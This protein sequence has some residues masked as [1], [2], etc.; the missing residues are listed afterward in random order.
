MFGENEKCWLLL[1]KRIGNWW[2]CAKLEGFE[3]EGVP[4]RVHFDGD[5]VLKKEEEDQ[6]VVGW[7]HTHPTFIAYPSGTD[8]ATMRAWAGC[9]GKP[10]LCGIKG[11]DGLKFY[12]YENDEDPGRRVRHVKILNNYYI[13]G[14]WKMKT[15]MKN[16]VYLFLLFLIGCNEPY[17]MGYEAGINGKLTA[18]DNPFSVTNN[19]ISWENGFDAGVENRCYKHDNEVIERYRA[20]L[21]DKKEE[22][23]D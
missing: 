1:G 7:I 15:K 4:T 12:L 11:T 20:T 10:L 22:K 21:T 3:H 5:F 16:L 8:D 6:S 18:A 17:N 19:K 13:F 23:K 2:H 14:G 9:F